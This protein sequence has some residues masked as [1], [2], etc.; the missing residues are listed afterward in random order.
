MQHT[1]AFISFGLP[2]F[3]GCPRW[4][5]F[6]MSTLDDLILRPCLVLGKCLPAML[7]YNA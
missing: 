1:F 3:M 6:K 5:S 4:M 2:I 7:K